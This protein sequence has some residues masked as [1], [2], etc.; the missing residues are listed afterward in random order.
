MSAA[1]EKKRKACAGPGLGCG[2]PGP[3]LHPSATGRHLQGSGAG[4]LPSKAIMPLYPIHGGGEYAHDVQISGDWSNPHSGGF[5]SPVII[6]CWTPVGLPVGLLLS[7]LRFESVE[8][9]AVIHV[10]SCP[11]LTKT[12]LTGGSMTTY[13]INVRYKVRDLPMGSDVKVQ[14]A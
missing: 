12:Q 7:Q 9:F 10:P 2:R 1:L 13:H 14:L 8:L 3:A 11:A 6:L 4:P 5:Q